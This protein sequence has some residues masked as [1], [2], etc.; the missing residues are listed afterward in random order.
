MLIIRFQKYDSRAKC[1]PSFDDSL[2]V[3]FARF[4]VVKVHDK[5]KM[6]K[7]LSLQEAKSVYFSKYDDVRLLMSQFRNQLACLI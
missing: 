5:F 3:Q 6:F 2:V 7:T 4:I 1:V